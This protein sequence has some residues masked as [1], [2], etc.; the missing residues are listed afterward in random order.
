[1]PNLNAALGCAQMERA[2][3]CA[4]RKRVCRRGIALPALRQD[5]AFMVELPEIIEHDSLVTGSRNADGCL[6]AE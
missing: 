5:E 1:M 2:S 4:C 6:A 3:G